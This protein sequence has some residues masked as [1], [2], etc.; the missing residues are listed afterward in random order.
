MEDLGVC[1]SSGRPHKSLGI[2]ILINCKCEVFP[3]M[4]VLHKNLFVGNSAKTNLKKIGLIFPKMWVQPHQGFLWISHPSQPFAGCRPQLSAFPLRKPDWSALSYEECG[5]NTQPTPRRLGQ[6]ST[7]NTEIS[8]DVFIFPILRYSI[9]SLRNDRRARV[10]FD[11]W[12]P[13]RRIIT[14]GG[15]D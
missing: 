8:R 15:E 12:D 6:P 11:A 13:S 1:N 2:A 9:D 3:K 4:W 14:V 7:N 10:Y 5:G